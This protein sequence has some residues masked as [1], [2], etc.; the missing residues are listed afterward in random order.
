MLDRWLK[1]FVELPQHPRLSQL[2][3]LLLLLYRVRS[4][5]R[6]LHTVLHRRCEDVA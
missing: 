2:A 5:T 3:F 1:A 4:A 6:N